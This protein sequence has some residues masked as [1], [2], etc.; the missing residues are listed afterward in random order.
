MNIRS[1]EIKSLIGYMP[2]ISDL[3]N[4]L[5]LYENF[6]ISGSLYSLNKKDV[7]ERIFN[8]SESPLTIL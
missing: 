4:S 6:I 8:L 5:S 7:S 1:N 3:N 2:Q